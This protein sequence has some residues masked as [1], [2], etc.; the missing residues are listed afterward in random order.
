MKTFG[1]VAFDAHRDSLLNDPD[2]PGDYERY[3]PWSKQPEFVHWH[4]ESVARAVL[5]E[6]K[7]RDKL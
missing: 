3:A 4:W 7:K 6:K 5:N 2:F 1:Q